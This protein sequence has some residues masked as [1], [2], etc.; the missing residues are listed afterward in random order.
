M[1][2]MPAAA[3]SR[4]GLVVPRR[5]SRPSKTHVARVPRAVVAV[6]G[7]ERFGAGA[8]KR[9]DDVG[10]VERRGTSRRR[11]RRTRASSTARVDREPHRAAG[12]QQVSTLRRRSDT[13]QPR[14]CARAELVADHVAEVADR[15]DDVGDAF[16]TRASAAGGRR[17][18]RRR[19]AAAASARCRSPGACASRVRRRARGTAVAS[20]P[21]RARRRRRGRTRSGPRGD[22]HPSWPAGPVAGPRRRTAGSRPRRRR[23]ACRRARRCAA[24]SSYHS[25]ICAFEMPSDRLRLCSQCS[26]MSVGELRGVARLRARSRCASP[27]SFT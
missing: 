26:C 3:G 5:P 14:S 8:S 25:S 10:Q 11:A 15:V 16:A 23:R 4:L 9:R 13:E 17:T 27:R 2:C 6:H 1:W 7:H 19:P 24:R 20:A 22:R 12:A 21:R 18:A